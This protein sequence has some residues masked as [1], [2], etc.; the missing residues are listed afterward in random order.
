MSI[1][2]DGP[3]HS[4]S[5]SIPKAQESAHMPVD[6]NRIQKRTATRVTLQIS[7][8]K[9]PFVTEWTQTENISLH[10]IRMVTKRPWNPEERVVVRS[11]HGSIQSRARVIYCVPMTEERYAV[12][13]ELFSAVSSWVDVSSSA[14]VTL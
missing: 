14:T 12:G 11:R 5:Y 2:A 9:R 4:V 8:A 10:G 6:G 1:I 13:L 3:V 7:T